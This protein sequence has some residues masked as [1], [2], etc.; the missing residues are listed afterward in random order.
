ME[1]DQMQQCYIGTTIAIS[2]H[3]KKYMKTQATIAP[4]TI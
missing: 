4:K 2:F 1:S 3:I